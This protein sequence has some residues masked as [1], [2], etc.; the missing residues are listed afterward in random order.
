MHVGLQRWK[1]DHVEVRFRAGPKLPDA[2]AA[3]RFTRFPA[4]SYCCAEATVQSG[5]FRGHLAEV[6]FFRRDVERFAAELRAALAGHGS[7]DIGLES[8][9]P[10]ECVLRIGSLGPGGEGDFTASLGRLH[11]ETGE[12]AWDRTTVAFSLAPSGWDEV[13]EDLDAVLSMPPD[14][15]ET[16]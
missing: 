16:A 11:L 9:S 6:Y 14:N 12:W 3:V 13:F 1:G 2:F 15:E 5:G 10:G 4:G 7:G 8:I